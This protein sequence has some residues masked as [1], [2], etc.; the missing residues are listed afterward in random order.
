MI[1]LFSK[2]HIDLFCPYDSLE[3]IHNILSNI[4]YGFENEASKEAK[5]DG[6]AV[7]RK[8]LELNLLEVFHW[9][10]EHSS[11]KGKS[12]TNEEILDYVD[13]IWKEGTQYPDFYGLVMF[14]YKDWYTNA[15]EE[16]GLT[17][18]TDWR[19]FAN[20]KIGNIEDFIKKHSPQ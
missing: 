11:R 4:G 20:T 19:T 3:F 10:P 8:L 6:L 17:M 1:D 12:Y 14:K 7:I 16:E 2:E 9:G 15:L 13:A 5:A 18:F